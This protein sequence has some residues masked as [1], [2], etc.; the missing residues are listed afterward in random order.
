ME[1]ATKG[2]EQYDTRNT[3][4]I[5]TPS[6]KKCVELLP[7]REPEVRSMEEAVERDDTSVQ[8]CRVRK[9]R[10]VIHNCEAKGVKTR[11]GVVGEEE[12]LWLQI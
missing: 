9:S 2:F 8:K 10:C 12:N 7:M 3:N 1:R 4:V 5:P 6:V 11:M